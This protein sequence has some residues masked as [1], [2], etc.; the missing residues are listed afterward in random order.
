MVARVLGVFTVADAE[1]GTEVDQG[2]LHRYLAEAVWAPTALLPQCGVEWTSVDDK[3][4]SA[5]L[6]VGGTVVSLDFHFGPD[7]LVH[8]VYTPARM[9][10]VQGRF[11]I[12]PWQGRFERYERRGGVLIPTSAEVEWVL[13]TTGAQVYWRGEIGDV[14]YDS[15]GPA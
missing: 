5:S 11:D 4:A 12:T 1:G 8:R 3:T 9:R 2:E 14:I 6:T 15:P 10:D 13:P 7:D